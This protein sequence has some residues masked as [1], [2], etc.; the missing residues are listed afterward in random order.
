[1]SGEA[2]RDLLRCESCGGTVLW[3]AAA[4]EAAC[5][6]CGSRTLAVLDPDARLPTPEQWLPMTVLASEAQARFRAWATA[7]WFRPKEL[8]EAEVELRP[9]LLPVWRMDCALETH[10]AGLRPALTT[11]SKKRPVAGVAELEARVLVPA[12]AGL[13]PAELEALRPFDETHAEAWP[14]REDSPAEDA[15]WDP[16]AVWEPP[17]L[18]RRGARRRAHAELCER[19]RREISRARG[20]VRCHVSPLIEDREVA[21]LMVP[22]Y[23]GTF[24]FRDRPWRCVIQGQSGAVVGDAPVDRRKLALVVAAIVAVVAMVIAALAWSS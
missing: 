21:L 3:D 18:T 10:W 19:H 2:T 8:R 11:D 13:S 16:L 9:M 15:R 17:A 4:V 22:V 1:M 23:I 20:L 24:R 5:L 14:G 12:S 7:S 6:F